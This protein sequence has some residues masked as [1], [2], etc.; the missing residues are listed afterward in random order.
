M[1]W[2]DGQRKAQRSKTGT[3]EKVQ[4]RFSP[5]VSITPDSYISKHRERLSI[6]WSARAH[7]LISLL[8]RT[9]PRTSKGHNES[10]ERPSSRAH[11]SKAPETR[12]QK[13]ESKLSNAMA[14]R[15]YGTT[16]TVDAQ[17]VSHLG[18]RHGDVQGER[19]STGRETGAVWRPTKPFSPPEIPSPLPAKIIFSGNFVYP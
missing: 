4:G 19:E 17:M 5:A 18:S 15:P 13:G 3:S 12:A 10:Q 11:E 16:M 9:N 6:R 2:R 8:Q 7:C 14:S 1:D